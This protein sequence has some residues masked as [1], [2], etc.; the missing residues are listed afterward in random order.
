MDVDKVKPAEDESKDQTPVPAKQPTPQQQAPEQP[1][2]PQQQPGQGSGSASQKA[3]K[4]SAPQVDLFLEAS[5]LPLDVAI[6]NSVRAAGSDDKIR[7]YLQAVLVVGGTALTRGMGDALDSR[8]VRLLFLFYHTFSLSQASA[9][10]VE[11]AGV[12]EFHSAS[13]L[14]SL[15]DSVFDWNMEWF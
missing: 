10:E 1:Q 4:E 5:K 2:Q 8:Y 11:C 9:E 3:S 7:K 15:R 13:F 14:F 12:I 6:F